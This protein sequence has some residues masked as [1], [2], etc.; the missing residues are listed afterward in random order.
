MKIIFFVLCLSLLV[1]NILFSQ[2]K[3]H[4]E[5]TIL[6]GLEHSYHFKWTEAE[7]TFRDIIEKN[8][9]SP[10][11]YH[12][13]S[14]VYAWYYLSGKNKNDLDSF[15][16]ISDITLDKGIEE[17]DKNSDDSWL[18]Y[19][20]GSNYSYRAIV[21]AAAENY[22]D[23]VWAGKKSDSYLSDVL[24]TSPQNYDAYLGIGLFNF[25]AGQT[26]TA[27]RWALKLA[28][29]SGDIETGLA[30][31]KSA[32][33]KGK[34]SNVEAQYYYSQIVTDYSLASKMLTSLVKKYPENILFT[35]SLAA[36]NIKERKLDS[37][38]KILRKIINVDYE[39]FGQVIS[40]SN[41]LLGDV[42][43]KKNNFDSAIVYYRKFLETTPDNDYTGIASYR[44]GVSYEITGERDSASIY[45][46]LTAN[47][48]MDL[49]DDIY[50]KR[51]GAVFSKRSMYVHEKNVIKASNLID[52]GNYLAAYDSLTSILDEIVSDELKAETYLY[53]SETAFYL[54]NYDESVSLASAALQTNVTDEKWILPYANYYAA[55]SNHKTGDDQAVEY[56]LE[57]IEKYSDYD[58]QNKMKNLIYSLKNKKPL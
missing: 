13:L 15:I 8:P 22:L 4:L 39:K 12:F 7:E 35:Y 30:Q 49:D 32:A 55:R 50:A 31:I 9:E 3:N 1:S 41:F 44:L 38:E 34:F 29:I 48:N 36:L 17:L 45:F 24:E 33:E 42:Y 20:I 52:S 58:Y 47:G 43:Y 57:E 56:F 27:L 21:F 37:A 23:A 40:F 14:S 18:N 54:G 26:P 11:G 53:L 19:I 25:A 10:E 16:I 28:G 5:K 51:K 2:T 46:G 6:I